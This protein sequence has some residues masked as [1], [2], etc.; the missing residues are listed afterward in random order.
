MRR[1]MVLGVSIDCVGS[2]INFRR[3]ETAVTN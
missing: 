2:A 3:S 1:T